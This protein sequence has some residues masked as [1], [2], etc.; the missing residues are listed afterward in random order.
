ME[1]CQQA[2]RTAE[3]DMEKDLADRKCQEPIPEPMVMVADT[4]TARK[5]DVCLGENCG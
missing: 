1:V 4:A 5:E 2:Q 3:M